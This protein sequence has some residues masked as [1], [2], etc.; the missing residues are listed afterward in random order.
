VQVVHTR[1]CHYAV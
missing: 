1:A